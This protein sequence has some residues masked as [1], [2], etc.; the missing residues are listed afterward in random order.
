MTLIRDAAVETIRDN[1]G[2]DLDL[3]ETFQ[4]GNLNIAAETES[5]NE[6]LA[7]ARCEARVTPDIVSEAL[8]HWVSMETLRG[9]M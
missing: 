7:D 3:A 5:V 1:W 4:S 8:S 9:N 2:H 6:S